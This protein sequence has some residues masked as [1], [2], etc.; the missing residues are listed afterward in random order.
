MIY[1]AQVFN[2]ILFLGIFTVSGHERLWRDKNAWPRGQGD[3]LENH[4]VFPKVRILQ[5][6]LILDNYTILMI[7]YGS[8]ESIKPLKGCSPSD[9][10]HPA[11]FS[12]PSR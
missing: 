9:L 5:F 6:L 12:K 11:V 7:D 3:G 10:M 4:W 2:K 8:I 1:I